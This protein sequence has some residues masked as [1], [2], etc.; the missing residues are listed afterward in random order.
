[1]LSTIK[2]LQIAEIIELL[3]LFPA[4]QRSSCMPALTAL[5][6]S[7]IAQRPEGSEQN[8]IRLQDAA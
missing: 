7:L 6:I 1:M 5:Y 8:V 4:L 3:L 2:E